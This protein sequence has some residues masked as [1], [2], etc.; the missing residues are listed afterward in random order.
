MFTKRMSLIAVFLG[1][2]LLPTLAQA[3]TETNLTPG[4]EEV[5]RHSIRLMHR[6][7]FRTVHEMHGRANHCIRIIR[8]L[9]ERGEEERAR[10]VAQECIRSINGLAEHQIGR[11]G[12]IAER[13]IQLLR[14]MEAPE[15]LIEAVRRAARASA[16]RINEGRAREVRRIEEA[17]RGG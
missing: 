11:I 1:G 13:C 10:E 17:L 2:M 15:E 8:E 6:V 7:T 16:G 5:A 12:R 9:L 14:E 3:A 4:P